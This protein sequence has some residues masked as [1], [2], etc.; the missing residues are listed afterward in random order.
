MIVKY[1]DR[2]I[3]TKK[4]AYLSLTEVYSYFYTD[5]FRFLVE[6]ICLLTSENILSLR[7]IKINQIG[8]IESRLIFSHVKHIKNLQGL[9]IEVINYQQQFDYI[10]KHGRPNKRLPAFSFTKDQLKK[11]YAPRDIVYLVY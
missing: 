2:A 4:L 11:A 1:K 9:L 8:V 5:T 3:S 6:C 10:K 7:K